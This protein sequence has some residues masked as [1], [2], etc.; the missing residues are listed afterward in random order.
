M[1]DQE[2]KVILLI[3]QSNMEGFSF[4]QYLKTPFQKSENVRI[5]YW[6]NMEN[7]ENDVVK[8]GYGY[9]PDCFGAEIGISTCLKEYPDSSFL[10]IKYAIGGTN[11]AEQW[12]SPSKGNIGPCY[13]GTINYVKKCFE[14]LNKQNKKA[15]LVSIVWMQGNSDCDNP[16]WVKNYYENEHSLI[17]DLR[18]DLFIYSHDENVPFIDVL[19][20]DPG[21]GQ[22]SGDNLMIDEA[23]KK[24]VN[25]LKNAYLVD[26]IKEGLSKIQ[27]PYNNVDN[28]HYDAESEYKL[29]ILMGETIIKA[30]HLRR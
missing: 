12:M 15:K 1:K 27:E 2:I 10:L 14:Y 30:L 24:N 17:L 3:G 4:C 26:T 25:S 11:L 22:A 9:I 16:D 28:L 8:L 6:K 23:K 21:S 29:G 20:S 19:V 13:E 7:G 18:K 5:S